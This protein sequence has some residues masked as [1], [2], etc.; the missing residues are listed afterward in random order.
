M[1]AGAPQM[2]IAGETFSRAR[3]R[4]PTPMVNPSGIPFGHD[5]CRVARDLRDALIE[6]LDGVEVPVGPATGRTGRRSYRRRILVT[7]ANRDL[8]QFALGPDG[9][10]EAS[11]ITERGRMELAKLFADYADAFLRAALSARPNNN[12]IASSSSMMPISVA[13]R[14]NHDDH[15][16]DIPAQ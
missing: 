15:M 7:L 2:H 11:V 4:S 9:E 10:P 6:H 5:S 16:P 8:I 12:I 1:D 14:R 13:T 3:E